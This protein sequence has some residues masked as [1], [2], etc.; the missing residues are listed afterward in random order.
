M[1]HGM[2]G[3]FRRAS[4]EFFQLVNE[5]TTVGQLAR[6]RKVPLLTRLIAV[7][8]GSTAYWVGQGRAKPLSNP[9]FEANTLQP[10]KVAALVITSMELLQNSDVRTEAVLREDLV[11][12]LAQ[13]IDQ[14]FL[15]P[16]GPGD[17]ATPA[18]IINNVISV[19]PTSGTPADDTAALLA[20]LGSDWLSPVFIMPGFAAAQ[21][22]SQTHP[23]VGFSGGEVS[24][25][26]VVTSPY[27]PFGLIVL[28]DAASVAVAEGDS[29]VK[30]SRDASIEM[31][32]TPAGDALTATGSSLVSLW[33]SNAVGLLAEHTINWRLMRANA[34]VYMENVSWATPV[35]ST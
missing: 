33:Q 9:T 6:A 19:V 20:H 14:A 32:N 11:R 1:A 27:V 31:S 22:T 23:N 21:L 5:R 17:D 25:I 30:V 18:S 15:D 13:A 24:G 2:L 16:S 10:T 12:S 4:G 3:L 35:V 26:P 7:A 8:S 34:A 29:A 28:L